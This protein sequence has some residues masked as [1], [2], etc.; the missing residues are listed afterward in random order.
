MIVFLLMAAF[1]AMSILF[2][3]CYCGKYATEQ[4]DKICD[5]VY[6]LNWNVLPPKLQKFIIII[7][8]NTQRPLLYHGFYI[9]NLDLS[10]FVQVRC[11]YLSQYSNRGKA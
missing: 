9:I 7:I 8:A 5:S 10:T 11:C 2:F 1:I 6:E 4:F 3:Y